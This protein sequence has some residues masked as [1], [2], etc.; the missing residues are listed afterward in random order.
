MPTHRRKAEA[1]AAVAESAPAQE[2]IAPESGRWAN[3]NTPNP[4]EGR[5]TPTVGAGREVMRM[6]GQ[7]ASSPA[8]AFEARITQEVGTH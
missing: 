1:P 7:N 8:N 3:T 6:A 4:H 2:L 5:V